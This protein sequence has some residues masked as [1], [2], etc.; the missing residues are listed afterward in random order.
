MKKIIGKIL[1]LILCI[2]IFFG[3]QFTFAPA[4]VS[5][6]SM[7][8]TYNDHDVVLGIKWDRDYNKGDVV[9][10]DTSSY[11]IGANFII[12]RVIALPGDTVEIK[13]GTLLINDEEQDEPYINETMV[14]NMAKMAVSQDSLFIMGDN[15]NNSIDSRFFGEISQKDVYAKVVYENDFI[16]DI[17]RNFLK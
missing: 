12:K 2:G 3:V 9:I 6:E 8:P 13:D 15:R 14:G 10:V 5:G 4:M 17:F 7:L 16:S 11:G 1:F